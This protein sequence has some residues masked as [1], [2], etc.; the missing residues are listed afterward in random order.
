MKYD[1]TSIIDRS[2]DGSTKWAGMLK[3]NPNVGPDVL[4]MSTADM[5]FMIAPEIREGLKKHIDT[6]IPGY[7]NP[8]PAYYEAVLCWQKERH[9]DE[10]KAEWIVTTS[11][12]VSAIFYLVNILTQ[13]GEGVI[14]QRPVYYP[15]SMAAEQTGRTLV[16]NELIEKED[17]DYPEIIVPEAAVCELER[18]GFSSAVDRAIDACVKKAEEMSKK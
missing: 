17:L 1:F 11:G 7:T 2:K 12:V 15:F 6:V 8:T 18:S 4:P 9:N 14:I 10:G 5:E 3:M 13:P 16:I